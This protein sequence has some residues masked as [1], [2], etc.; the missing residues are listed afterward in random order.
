MPQSQPVGYVI[1]SLDARLSSAV[2]HV[3]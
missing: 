2:Q 1:D 3:S